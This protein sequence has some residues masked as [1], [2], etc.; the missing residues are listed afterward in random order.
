MFRSLYWRIGVGLIAFL[1]MF[2]LVYR[3]CYAGTGEDCV[4]QGAACKESIRSSSDVE[5][6]KLSR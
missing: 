3:G 4:P 5:V 6:R 1:A 2:L